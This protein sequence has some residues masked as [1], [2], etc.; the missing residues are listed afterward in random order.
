MLTGDDE[1]YWTVQAKES[2][3]QNFEEL[4]F[5][6]DRLQN[7]DFFL[8][9]KIVQAKKCYFVYAPIFVVFSCILACGFFAYCKTR[10]NSRVS[11]LTPS[12]TDCR[13]ITFGGA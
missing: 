13:K 3:K 1:G 11:V 5:V 7:E 4:V 2:M 10:S 9:E 12:Q 8:H 6:A